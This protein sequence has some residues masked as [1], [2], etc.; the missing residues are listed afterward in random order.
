[1]TANG[2][3]RV[4]MTDQDQ[5]VTAALGDGFEPRIEEGRLVVTSAIGAIVYE[6]A[7]ETAR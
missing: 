7:T 3:R 1:M 4:V 5:I 6:R 2:H